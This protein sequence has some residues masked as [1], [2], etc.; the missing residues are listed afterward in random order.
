[1]HWLIYFTGKSQPAIQIEKN[2]C[3]CIANYKITHWLRNSSNRTSQNEYLLITS[4]FIIYSS[5][6][7]RNLLV[8]CSNDH[9]IRSILFKCYTVENNINIII[10]SVSFTTHWF[11][12]SAAP[13]IA[14]IAS[15]CG[16][17]CFL[18]PMWYLSQEEE[19]SARVLKFANS[20]HC[21]IMW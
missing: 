13:F 16:S 6:L 21:L 19:N 4:T 15:T 9:R 20:A 10:A 17:K 5:P 2:G 3:N 1:M 18:L 11:Y 8:V 7:F 14:D 12:I